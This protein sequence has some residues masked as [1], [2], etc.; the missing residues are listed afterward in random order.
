MTNEVIEFKD[1]PTDAK[2]AA[3]R[4]RQRVQ[5]LNQEIG[6]AA[7]LFEMQCTI[8]LRTGGKAIDGVTIA[9]MY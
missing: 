2:D 9:K 6:M 4:I 7:R 3:A 1:Y 8:R 5:D